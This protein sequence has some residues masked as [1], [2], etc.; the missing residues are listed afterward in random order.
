MI[1]ERKMAEDFEEFFDRD[2]DAERPRDRKIDEAKT[3]LMSRFF[4]DKGTN[5]YYG[6]QLEIA[7]ENDFFHWITKKALNELAG[8][9]RIGF[10]V[11]QRE[12]IVA[13]FYWAK[14]HR[15][16]RRQIREIMGLIKEFAD[17]SFT[18]ALGK[19]GEL[20][21]DAGI[22]RTGFRI[23][24]TKVR[25]V[26]GRKWTKTNHDLDR[27]IERDGV[28][29]GVEIKNQLGYID[30]TEFQVKLEMC[31]HFQVRPMF[32]ARMMPRNYNDAV[33]KAGGFILLMKNQHY[34]LLSD[35]LAKRVRER[36][37]LPVLSITELPDTTM[38]RFEDWHAKRAGKPRSV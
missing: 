30:Q 36:L 10:C 35:G 32:V 11:E 7:L 33:I 38:R 31:D 34:P 8:E 26:D 9:K 25:A 3:E 20:L 24:Q 27:L 28:R 23:I 4:P 17:P 1:D 29:Y 14:R 2:D 15:Y 18:R 21:F 13:H 37:G 12:E 22:A 19:H 6:R 5:V 16:P